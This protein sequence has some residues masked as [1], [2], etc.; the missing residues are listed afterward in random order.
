[1]IFHVV[2]YHQA[3][4]GEREVRRGD[5]RAQASPLEIRPRFGRNATESRSRLSARRPAGSTA[6]LT[7][8][9][10]SQDKPR[11]LT[12][13]SPICWVW[14]QSNSP[15]ATNNSVKYFREAIAALDPQE[16]TY[17]QHLRD[18]GG[19]EH[20]PPRNSKDVGTR[21]ASMAAHNMAPRLTP[22]RPGG[23]QAFSL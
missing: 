21:S 11:S 13:E 14:P 12:P 17:Q 1:M 23:R 7:M 10:F 18:D 20:S 4:A 16:A 2:Q 6:L 8:G 22:A 19:D 5:R 15:R 3:H 9:G